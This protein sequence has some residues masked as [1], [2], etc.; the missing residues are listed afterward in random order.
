[1]TKRTPV[2]GAVMLFIVDTSYR[3][4]QQQQ[5]HGRLVRVSTTTVTIV[6]RGIQ[7]LSDLVS[8]SKCRVIINF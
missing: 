2:G 4:Q 1:M 8:S 5:Q 6:T 7:L 3:W